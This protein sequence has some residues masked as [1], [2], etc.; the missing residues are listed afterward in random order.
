ML[1]S[2]LNPDSLPEHRT[3]SGNPVS[4]DSGKGTSAGRALSRR[5]LFSGLALALIG[6]TFIAGCMSNGGSRR[7]HLSQQNTQL[8]AQNEIQLTGSDVEEPTTKETGLGDLATDGSGLRQ[9]NSLRLG[10]SNS[11]SPADVLRQLERKERMKLLEAKSQLRAGNRAYEAGDFQ[12][13]IENYRLALDNDPTLTEARQKLNTALQLSGNR[14]GE[15]GNVA[16]AV[17][18]H[19]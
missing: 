19:S 7:R 3:D 16:N 17:R 5:F 4:G 6:S 11:G 2:A 1:N 18:A 15:A 12:Q 13:A 8:D 14:A 10:Q 9:A